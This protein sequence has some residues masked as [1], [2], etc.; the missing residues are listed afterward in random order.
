MSTEPQATEPTT[1]DRAH[2]LDVAVADLTVAIV[3]LRMICDSA[4]RGLEKLGHSSVEIQA[5]ASHTLTCQIRALEVSTQAKLLIES[6][7]RDTPVA[8]QASV[9]ALH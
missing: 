5:M 3:Q 8:P 4:C 7:D 2:R 6:K 1:A 9:R